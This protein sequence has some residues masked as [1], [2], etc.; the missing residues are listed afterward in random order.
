V[1]TVLLAACG[2]GDASSEMRAT[3]T[4]D[5][6]TYE[7]DGTPATGAFTVEVENQSSKD[8]AFALARIVAGATIDDLEAYLEEVQQRL[9]QGKGLLPPPAF[10]SQ[11]VRVGVATGTSSRLP[12]DVAAGTYALTCFIDDPPTAIYLATPLEVS[13]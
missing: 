3:L 12:A 9:Q 1:T 13:E 8:A 11:V 7:G 6:C 10:Y 2:G 5:D 4:D